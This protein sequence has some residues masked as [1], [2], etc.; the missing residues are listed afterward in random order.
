[1]LEGG[2]FLSILNF[3]LQYFKIR[4]GYRSVDRV[5]LFSDIKLR[6]TGLVADIFNLSS[7]ET[8]AGGSL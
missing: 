7:R 1:M 3:P 4:L 2:R 6:L 8:V 5:T